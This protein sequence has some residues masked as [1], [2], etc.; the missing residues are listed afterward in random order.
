[1]RNT[2]VGAA[3]VVFA[4]TN[5]VPA[6]ADPP[7][8]GATECITGYVPRNARPGDVVCVTPATQT[9]V[10]AENADPDAH[11]DP[12]AGSGAQSCASGWVWRQAFDGDTI[13]VT[14]DVRSQTL[15]DN[16]AA[17]S[18]VVAGSPQAPPAQPNTMVWTATGQGP[19]YNINI[20]DDRNPQTI[21]GKQLPFTHT[22]VLTV[23]PGDLYQIVVSGKGDATVGCEISYNGRVV[24]AQPVNNS[25][26]QCIWNVPN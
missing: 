14:P 6:F 3:C 4:M 2:I 8:N 26:A 20:D 17:N 15:A 13:C 19:T 16:A 18:R 12:N 24:A 7:A 9:Q 1:M 5:S 21:S 22:E 11:R 10:A 23:K 25:S